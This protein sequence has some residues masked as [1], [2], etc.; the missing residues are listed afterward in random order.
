MP[1]AVAIAYIYRYIHL[2][3]KKNSWIHVFWAACAD[4]LSNAYGAIANY[5]V[6]ART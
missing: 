5:E 1:I 3:M 6:L 2:I 4:E